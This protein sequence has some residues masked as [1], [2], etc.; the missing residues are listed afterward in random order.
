MYLAKIQI[1]EGMKFINDARDLMQTSMLLAALCVPFH[2][3]MLEILHGMC[4]SVPCN[5][6]NRSGRLSKRLYMATYWLSYYKRLGLL[7]GYQTTLGYI[8]IINAI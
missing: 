2:K 1:A 6:G 5:N 3:I 7:G 4:R 8:G